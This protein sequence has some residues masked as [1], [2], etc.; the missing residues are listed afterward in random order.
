MLSTILLSLKIAFIA[1]FITFILGT[2]ISYLL[3]KKDFIGKAQLETL[4]TL[5]MVLP[6][7]VVGYGL[8]I[9]FGRSG[10]IG[11]RLYDYFGVQIVFTAAGAVIAATIVSLPL[12]VQSVK[13]AFSNV[14]PVYERVAESLGSGKLKVF[15]T[16][17]LPLSWTGIVGGVMLAFARALGEFGATLMIAGN[18]PGKTQTIPL[19]IYF[20]VETGDY[21]TA[22]QLMLFMILFSF[23]IIGVT[24]HWVK[25]KHYIEMMRAEK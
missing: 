18:I 8:L 22:N 13:A 19:A 14:D 21:I 25:K 9:L 15:L 10:F 20:A 7:S 3:I 16:V 17:T 4:L 23:F 11:K 24:N 5:P 6:P 12:M 1:T 2:A